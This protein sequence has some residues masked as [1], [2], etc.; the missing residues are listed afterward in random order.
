MPICN[1]LTACNCSIISLFAIAIL[2][3][4]IV[5][6]N[7]DTC[8][9]LGICASKSLPY[10]DNF[11][12]REE[13]IRNI[14]GYLD[15][16]NSDVQV[17]HI[18][19]PPGFGKSTLAIKIGDIF[20]RKRFYVHYV[21][22]RTVSDM[23]TLAEKAMLSIVES[24]KNK[25]TFDRLEKWV[26]EQYSKTLIILD[27]CDELLERKKEEFLEGINSLVVLPRRNVRY[28]LTSQKWVANIGN[29]QLHA[30][31]NL[32]SEASIQL[33]GRLAPS[34][35]D[36]QKMEIA[37]LTGNVP[38]ALDVI[39]AIFKFPNAPTAEEVIQ[40]LKENPLRTLSPPMIHSTVHVSIGLAY[41]YLTPEL[42]QL[43]LNLSHFPGSFDEVSVIAIFSM[44]INYK[45]NLS[46][47]VQR[48]LLQFNSATKRY[49]LHH[50]IRKYF[51]QVINHT[52]RKTHLQHFDNNFQ[53]HFTQTL[54]H[55]INTM[56]LPFTFREEKHNFQYM[57]SLFK[58]AND[59]HTFISIKVKCLMCHWPSLS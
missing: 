28:L 53:I 31:Y 47:L 59:E 36:D 40:G 52:S 5:W 20:V 35:T 23:D 46:M 13:D 2:V 10:I 11:V 32:S 9:Q 39:G 3:L 1:F 29:F 25:V 56:H 54:I 14:T 16:A 30:I 26:R 6:A 34:L 18:V 58:K 8:Y 12:G 33:L 50:L 57:F 22:V 55:I 7:T 41:S 51:H 19:G 4:A 24:L 38:L 15:F 45:A 48:S 44:D 43:C 49:H 42:Q 37:T 17:V 27:N 21:D